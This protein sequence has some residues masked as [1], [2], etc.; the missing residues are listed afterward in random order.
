[1]RAPLLSRSEATGPP[2]PR[3]LCHFPAGRASVRACVR[4]L[5]APLVAVCHRAWIWRRRP[6]VRHPE[7]AICQLTPSRRGNQNAR[8][9]AAPIYST[10]G[11]ELWWEAWGENGGGE[12][13]GGAVT[14]P[15]TLPLSVPPLQSIMW[16]LP[17]AADRSSSFFPLSCSVPTQTAQPLPR[18]P[19]KKQ[20]QN[21]HF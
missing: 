2:P 11:S 1:M 6:S 4:A 8:Q 13:W 9:P 17:T 20:T 18:R 5:S 15:N 7:A 16:Q 14:P 21:Q 10:A 3:V 19:F 12:V